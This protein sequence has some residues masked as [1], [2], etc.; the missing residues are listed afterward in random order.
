MVSPMKLEVHVLLTL[1]LL[2]FVTSQSYENVSTLHD[3]LLQNY[4]TNIRPLNDQTG[5]M[6]VNVTIILFSIPD[7]D[8][9]RGAVSFV[10]Q[11]LVEWF[12]ERMVWTPSDHNNVSD[13]VLLSQDVW[14]P[15]VGIGNPIEMIK[16]G[17]KWNQVAYFP[18]GHAV[19]GPA[20]KVETSCSFYLKF[21]PFDKQICY[22]KLFSYGFTSNKSIL[23]VPGEAVISTF[24][25]PNGEWDLDTK[26][27]TFEY[28]ITNGGKVIIY[29]FRFTRQSTFYL[30]TI[31]L[32]LNA[33][34]ALTSLVFLL[35]SASGE[36][37]S[38]SITILLAL[39]VFLT[40][41]SEDLPKT[42]DPIPIMC[43]FILFGVMI[44]VAG[45]VIVIFNLILYH[46]DDKIPISPGYLR[47]VKLARCKRCFGKRRST[48]VVSIHNNC[49]NGEDRENNHN[50]S[51]PEYTKNV[52]SEMVI[53]NKGFSLDGR[54]A[55]VTWQDVSDAID[56]ISFIAMTFLSYIPM[57]AILVYLATASDFPESY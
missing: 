44:S 45:L 54:E 2:P 48:S 35:P 22:I 26:S 8:Q 17:E 31:I 16:F 50:T 4:R 12:D 43:V 29:H 5:D 6:I 21:W 14:T 51:V 37:A 18:D 13:I 42:S 41:I 55:D 34:G 11:L 9:V 36:R 30:L 33:V 56:K 39:A 7:V 1:C 57:T 27:I 23:N 19:F 52:Q 40:V 3:N 15:S 46:R 47:I 49:N 28:G 53:T 20:A 32:P 24:Y 10:I 38:Y 25:T